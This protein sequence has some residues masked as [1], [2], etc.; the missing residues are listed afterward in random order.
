MTLVILYYGSMT[1]GAA[2]KGKLAILCVPEDVLH[3]PHL[4]QVRRF[5]LNAAVAFQVFLS[6][7]KKQL[8]DVP[9]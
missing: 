7:A 5:K 1:D 3:L 6:P 2:L 8:L 9:R 4:F